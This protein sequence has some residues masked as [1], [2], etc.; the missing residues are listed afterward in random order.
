MH[1]ILNLKRN[2]P[3]YQTKILKPNKKLS[4]ETPQ[5]DKLKISNYYYPNSNHKSHKHKATKT[6][7]QPKENYDLHSGY[8]KIP[9]EKTYFVSVVPPCSVQKRI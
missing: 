8:L 3:Y 1:K 9:P 4:S 2:K 7:F 6:L 5:Q